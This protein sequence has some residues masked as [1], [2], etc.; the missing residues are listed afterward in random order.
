MPYLNGTA[1][2]F[3]ELQTILVNACTANGWSWSGSILSKNNIFLHLGS[4]PNA[5]IAIGGT[6]VSGG[7]LQGGTPRQL[8][9]RSRGGISPAVTWPVNY[10]VFIFDNEV[11]F[12]VNYNDVYYIYLAFGKSS[13]PMAGS[14]M[15]IA[16]SFNDCKSKINI[17]PGGGGHSGG[18]YVA[19]GIFYQTNVGNAA[20]GLNYYVHCGLDGR[21]WDNDFSNRTY[22]G[23]VG[24]GASYTQPFLSILPNQWN[25]EGILLPLRCFAIRPGNKSSIIAD[26]KNARHTRIDNFEPGQIVTIGTD[27]WKIYPNYRKNAAQRNGGLDIDH[28]GTIGWAVRYEGP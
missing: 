23:A 27:K 16:A 3:A 15:W 7:V 20:T 1:S 24:F 12:V 9:M 22:A 6:G 17:Y 4:S 28:S 26:L 14:G 21:G 5:L 13:I 10:E 25:S 11:Y 8:Q 18:D 2:S 19:P